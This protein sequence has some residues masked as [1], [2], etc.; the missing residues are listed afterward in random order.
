VT[1]LTLAVA[2]GEPMEMAPTPTTSSAP[3]SAEQVAQP[4][5][6]RLRKRLAKKKQA[7][8]RARNARLA[9]VQWSAPC[10][11]TAVDLRPG[12]PGGKP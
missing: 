3:M 4:R 11:L 5:W 7:T 2:L 1:K 8:I 9:M 10:Q 12:V 6:P